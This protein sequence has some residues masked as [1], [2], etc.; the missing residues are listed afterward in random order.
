MTIPEFSF[1]VKSEY[2]VKNLI[3]FHFPFFK[4]T[5]LIW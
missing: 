2:K 1:R 4:E 5:A 3:V